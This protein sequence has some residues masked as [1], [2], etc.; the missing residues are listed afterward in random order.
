LK[1]IAL[2]NM[3]RAPLNRIPSWIINALKVLTLV[4]FI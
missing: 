1:A 4:I 3:I 2:F